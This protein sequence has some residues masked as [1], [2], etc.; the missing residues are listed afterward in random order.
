[1]KTDGVLRALQSGG[2]IRSPKDQPSTFGVR[3]VGGDLHGQSASRHVL[4]T[5][6]KKRLL[7]RLDLDEHVEWELRE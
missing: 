2:R 7:R 1:M 3:I 4:T 6:V 5:M